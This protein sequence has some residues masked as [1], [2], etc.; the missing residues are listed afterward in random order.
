[1]L[2]GIELAKKR[3]FKIGIVTNSY[4]AT[5]VKDA[6][7]W[8]KDLS[9][10]K[11]SDFSISDDEFHYENGKKNLSKYAKAAAI[12]LG[13][14]INAI[15]IRKLES[16]ELKKHK[17]KGEFSAGE[18]LMV[19]GRAADLLIDKFPRRKWQDLKECPYEDLERLGR[20]HVDCF[21]NAQICQGLSIGNFWTTPLS[22]L[23]NSYDPKKHP[24]CGPLL[25]GGPAN[26]IENYNLEHENTYVD[27]CHLCYSA[28]KVLINKFPEYLGPRKVY[29][30]D[31]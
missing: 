5:C 18:E 1:M 31:D 21:G 22:E 23:V 12:R 7:L 29:G 6:E 3:G 13:L 27:E 26:L 28:R 16:L 10:L 30:L 19:R 15:K 8:L 25:K 4:W 14:P 20:I 17:E 24:I 2:K 11:I 9:E